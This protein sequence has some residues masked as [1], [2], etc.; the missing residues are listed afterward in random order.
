MK[1]PLFS[2][3]VSQIRTR[4]SRTLYVLGRQQNCFGIVG[5]NR[6]S[7]NKNKSPSFLFRHSNCIK[8]PFSCTASAMCSKLRKRIESICIKADRPR[9]WDKEVLS[10][11]RV[12]TVPEVPSSSL[13][14]GSSI[15]SEFF[16]WLTVGKMCG[17]FFLRS[18]ICQRAS[19]RQ[20]MLY[21]Q[22]IKSPHARYSICPSFFYCAFQL[23]S[24]FTGR[25]H[26]TAI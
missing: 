18:R 26:S 3:H 13:H 25:F 4:R 23:F 6:G 2:R 15:S 1:L 22:K 11:E 19:C 12:A 16:V 7:T 17:W 8:V 9:S 20:G 21:K 5:M 14:D 10:A 24:R